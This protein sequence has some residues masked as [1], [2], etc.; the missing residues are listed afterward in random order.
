MT[1]M[2]LAANDHMIDAL[3]SDRADQSFSIALLPRRSRGYRSVADA[4]GSNAPGKCPS[5]DPV[6]ITNE[7]GRHL[8]PAA[9]LVDL[10][11]DPLGSWMRG[12]AK[13]KGCVGGR[14]RE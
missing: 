7:V 10:P 9:G 12:D 2:S 14:V 5:I 4:H 3:A 8:V 6:A 13:P 1:Q 11:G